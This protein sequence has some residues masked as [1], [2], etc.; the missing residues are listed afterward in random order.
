MLFWGSEVTQ[1]YTQNEYKLSLSSTLMTLL[2]QR[3]QTATNKLADFI[4]G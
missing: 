4:G 1:V 2:L 3:K